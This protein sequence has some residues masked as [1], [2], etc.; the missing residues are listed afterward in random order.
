[1]AEEQTVVKP[2]SESTPVAESELDKT[3]PV[4][5]PIAEKAEHQKPPKGFVPYQALEE[6]R[7]LRKEAEAKL[8]NSAPSEGMD[9]ESFSDE[10]RAL[11]GDIK[12]LSEKLKVIER[13]ES[14][15]EVEIEFPFLKDKEEEFNA[16]LEDEENNRLSI[17]KAA[18][19]FAA[20]Q[21]LLNPEP[22]R[23]GLEK[24]TGGNRLPPEPAYTADE[25]RD[26]MKND[27]R[28]YEKLLKAG[29]II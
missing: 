28:K 19:L 8:E 7:R 9:E 22:A 26:L 23:K 12:A 6:E 2:A 18:R 20:E 17:K 1:M 29:K 14:R 4:V 5:S 3:Q 15:R 21:G 10:G 25:I 13:R 11:K 27:W 24:P 16:F